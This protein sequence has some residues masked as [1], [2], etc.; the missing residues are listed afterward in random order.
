MFS[1]AKE[2]DSPTAALD[3]VM[4]DLAAGLTPAFREL[5]PV[6]LPWRCDAVGTAEMMSVSTDPERTLVAEIVAG[7]LNTTSHV[8]MDATLAVVLV[9]LMFGGDG[10]LA[11]ELSTDAP[12][13]LA[14]LHIDTAASA[15]ALVAKLLER[16]LA[17]VRPTPVQ[18]SHM[19]SLGVAQANPLETPGAIVA[20]LT[21]DE[22]VTGTMHLVLPQRLAGWLAPKSTRAAEEEQA[23]AFD[24]P[25]WAE[26]LRS[27]VG[28]TPLK[29]NAVIAGPELSL[30]EVSA[31]KVGSHISLDEQCLNHVVLVS[32]GQVAFHCQLGQSNGRYTVSPDKPGGT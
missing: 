19:T 7:D 15:A 6:D 27:V 9:E 26:A 25:G 11:Q 23:Q 8:L 22:P 31:L 5:V 3:R 29:L 21:F 14:P 2:Q 17:A 10:T 4:V 18:C 20:A 16:R 13:R 30:A 12:V 1:Y 28:E 32:G 24:D